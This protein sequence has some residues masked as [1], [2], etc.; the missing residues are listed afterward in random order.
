MDALMRLYKK[1][2]CVVSDNETEFT[3]QAILKQ[4]GGLKQAGDNDLDSHYI[5]PGKPQQNAL[6][7]SFNGSLR[8]G[9][10]GGSGQRKNLLGLRKNCCL[11]AVRDFVNPNKLGFGV[12]VLI[13]ND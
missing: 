12:E 2:A 8:D 6:I 10:L 7:E 3:S 13:S 4:A 11:N 1:P 9:P 5:D